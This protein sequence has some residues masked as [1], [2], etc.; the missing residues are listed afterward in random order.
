MTPKIKNNIPITKSPPAVIN[1]F[2]SETDTST[3][4]DFITPCL[5]VFLI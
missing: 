5:E 1:N 2:F 3:E 4:R